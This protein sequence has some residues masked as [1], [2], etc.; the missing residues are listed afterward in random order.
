MLKLNLDWVCAVSARAP[1]GTKDVS[2]VVVVSIRTDAAIGLLRNP[3]E[4]M[5]ATLPV[6]SVFN[7]IHL[8][9]MGMV[10]EMHGRAV[11]S[12][13]ISDFFIFFCVMHVIVLFYN[14][15]LFPDVSIFLTSAPAPRHTLPARA[16]LPQR[17]F[18]GDQKRITPLPCLRV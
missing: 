6:I 2:A 10:S 4:C 9:S 3:D 15:F 5:G 16:I 12:E 11:F 13:K 14:G 8:H 1:V 17:R 7:A 18:A